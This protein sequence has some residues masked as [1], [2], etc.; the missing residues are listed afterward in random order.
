VP[1]HVL[2]Q[3]P[4]FEG[5]D[6]SFWPWSSKFQ[7]HMQGVSVHVA[8]MVS[9]VLADPAKAKRDFPYDE[10][11]AKAAEDLEEPDT[12]ISDSEEDEE[13]DASQ[14]GRQRPQ[15]KKE[16]HK[17]PEDW[18]KMTVEQ[19]KEWKEK[20]AR[21]KKRLSRR[22]HT[23]RKTAI[24]KE[25]KYYE[26]M[27]TLQLCLSVAFSKDNVSNFLRTQKTKG[28]IEELTAV[29]D[30]W[31]CISGAGR[32]ML[33]EEFERTRPRASERYVDWLNE[34]LAKKIQLESLRGTPFSDEEA[35]RKLFKKLRYHPAFGDK[36]QV[37]HY[38]LPARLRPNFSELCEA[39]KERWK[40]WEE[41]ERRNRFR[42]RKAQIRKHNDKKSRDG[43]QQQETNL[44]MDSK[45]K[46]GDNKP[47]P[48]T[49]P[50]WTLKVTCFGCD[51]KGHT[52]RY[53]PVISEKFRKEGKM[54]RNQTEDKTT[55]Q[56]KNE[57]KN[58]YKNKKKP[59]YKKK[60]ALTLITTD[61]DKNEDEQ[62]DSDTN[63]ALIHMGNTYDKSDD[64]EEERER[65]NEQTSSRH[66][67]ST[68]PQ[69][70]L[71]DTK[72]TP[73]VGNRRSESGE[74]REV[75]LV[76]ATLRGPSS[77]RGEGKEERLVSATSRCSPVTPNP[78]E[79]PLRLESSY[80]VTPDTKCAGTNRRKKPCNVSVEKSKGKG[81][82]QN[83]A[84]RL[85][86]ARYCGYHATQDPDY[87]E[88]DLSVSPVL[89]P[90]KSPYYPD[91]R[92]LK[93]AALE[94]SPKISQRLVFGEFET[95]RDTKIS[96]SPQ[97]S[98]NIPQ[99]PHE[100][101][102]SKHNPFSSQR[103]GQN[104]EGREESGVDE[105]EQRLGPTSVSKFGNQI[106][107]TSQQLQISSSRPIT[108]LP[109]TQTTNT[110]LINP[111]VI[112]FKDI[113]EI[114]K[115]LMNECVRAMNGEV[116]R[117]VSGELEKDDFLT[118]IVRAIEGVYLERA[119]RQ[120]PITT[121][122]QLTEEGEGE[123]R[124]VSEGELETET[125]TEGETEHVLIHVRKR[126]M[127]KRDMTV[128][129]SGASTDISCREDRLT[130]VDEIDPVEL[131]TGNGER[132]LS[133][134]GRARLTVI[135]GKGRPRAVEKKMLLD[136]TLPVSIVSTGQMD[137]RHNRSV[138]HQ[139]G[140][141]VILKHPIHINESDI[142]VRGRL[143]K[144]MIYRW[145]D[146]YDEPLKVN[147]RYDPFAT[148]G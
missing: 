87:P 98:Q 146:E 120:S 65:D 90:P 38:D 99:P 48:K 83:H 105:G 11:R 36:F 76:S 116:M 114:A 7:K 66:H 49:A 53:C 15:T 2:S 55:E 122:P 26:R 84:K 47:G 91:E 9:V 16:D 1:K 128:Q 44:L 58:N 39:S 126:V 74:G 127:K 23:R 10:A 142:L 94:K 42:E 124:G 40:M 29:R 14:R 33:E 50:N 30:Q 78:N 108:A 112:T 70:L 110:Q 6:Q 22:Q 138:I 52:M 129:D 75:R 45:G 143:T 24:R 106:G 32:Y 17:Q 18:D 141:L 27:K 71:N 57:Q 121:P 97:V 56:E 102:F 123:G 4:I 103:T 148:R 111:H 88:L 61:N 144:S 77:L 63:V 46:R 12:P 85:S 100:R 64:D 80:G 95:L 117:V 25:K 68:S 54:K 5:D 133:K 86:Y 93:A 130:D 72:T 34:F 132:E 134:S 104:R 13:S 79:T 82:Y 137:H 69:A 96:T 8:E 43:K 131:L 107:P 19:K 135:D 139:N 147:E 37:D 60:K 67:K 118:D 119:V 59:F 31:G 62:S 140:Q 81:A 125:E 115:T 20:E 41:K 145:D 101:K 73:R 3:V 92:G 21:K 109:P 113:N 28:P 35:K 136:T 51:A 89:R